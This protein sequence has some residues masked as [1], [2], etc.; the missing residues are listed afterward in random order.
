M[1]QSTLSISIYIGYIFIQNNV[2][3]NFSN[4]Y[5]PG[6]ILSCLNGGLLCFYYFYLALTHK[7]AIREG[8]LA[9]SLVFEIIDREPVIGNQESQKVNVVDNGSVEFV[10]VNYDHPKSN[11]PY[12]TCTNIVFEAEKCTTVIMPPGNGNIIS[13]FADMILRIF[14]VQQGQIL[15]DGIPIK[16]M[17]LIDY[18]E[19]IGYVSEN[20]TLFCKSVKQMFLESN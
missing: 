9:A 14:D 18:R 8:K 19:K 13:S 7:C 6:D 17:R 11:T 2:M 4:Y 20:P 16:R 12:F 1:I 10:N 15:I 3:N 5:S